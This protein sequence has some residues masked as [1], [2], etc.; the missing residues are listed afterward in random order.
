MNSSNVQGQ[1]PCQAAQGQSELSD[2]LSQNFAAHSNGSVLL[3]PLASDAMLTGV[4]GGPY[5]QA[6]GTVL[7][8]RPTG[9][10]GTT[11]A[12]SAQPGLTAADFLPITPLTQPMPQTVESVQ[13]LNGALRTQIGKRVT[14]SFLIGTNTF[15]DKTG[16]LLAVGANY[17]LMLETDTDDLLFC[18]FFSIKFIRIYR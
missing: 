12:P 5:A 17:I 10:I 7:Q 2:I 14:V 15:V 11:G 8:Q 1:M 18:D 13:Y 16:T 6:G 4:G 9:P 3:G